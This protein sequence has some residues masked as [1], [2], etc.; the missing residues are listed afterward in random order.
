MKRSCILPL[1]AL[2]ALALPARADFAKGVAAY[3]RKDY[4]AAAKEWE[5]DANAGNAAAQ[6][7]LG[8]L[9]LDGKGVPQDN[10]EA[11]V[12]LRR[13][14]D[15]GYAK[16]QHNLGALLG[17]GKGVKR[18][19]EQAYM[20]MSLCAASGE[21]GC[22]SQRDQLAEKLSKSKL[23][24]AQRRAREWRPITQNAQTP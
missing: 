20:W 8:M 21:A 14:A 16:A 1:I 4:P 11:A 7:N 23:Q 24:R 9:Y 3:E 17:S 5:P 18:D 12:W 2:V 13:A 6:F 15:Q 10:A 22:E 19:Y